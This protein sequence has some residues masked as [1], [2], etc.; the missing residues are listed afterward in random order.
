M[1]DE[2]NII[3]E[4]PPEVANIYFRFISL[5]QDEIVKI[6]HNKFK[7]ILRHMQGLHFNAFQDREKI[8]IKGGMLRLKKGFGTYKIFG[9]SLHNV[10]GEAFINYTVILVE[11][12]GNIILINFY[13]N[14][15]QL[16][17]IHKWQGALLAMVI[18]VHTYIISQQPSDPQ[19]TVPLMK[20]GTAPPR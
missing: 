17:K 12:F 7:A 16:S 20:V 3:G 1:G 13:G 6:F 8:G 2:D 11:F 14:I 4:I 10:W 9:K 15:F 19:S 5:P 18:E